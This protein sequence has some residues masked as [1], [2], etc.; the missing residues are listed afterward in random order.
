M[1]RGGVLT[2][3]P[4]LAFSTGWEKGRSTRQS[5]AVT[6]WIVAASRRCGRAPAPPRAGPSRPGRRR[7]GGT[8]AKGTDRSAPAPAAPRGGWW[9]ASQPGVRVVSEE[10]L[11]FQRRPTERPAIQHVDGHVTI[12][13]TAVGALHGIRRRQPGRGS[14]RLT[15]LGARWCPNRCL[16]VTG[17]SEDGQD[18]DRDRQ[19][20]GRRDRAPSRP[21]TS[22]ASEAQKAAG[23]MASATI[24]RS[25]AH[26][27]RRRRPTVP[28]ERRARQRLVL[29][30]GHGGLLVGRGANLRIGFALVNGR[31]V[32]AF[33]FGPK[34]GP[35]SRH[36][37]IRRGVGPARV[38]PAHR[39]GRCRR[40]SWPRAMRLP[41]RR[42]P[43][44]GDVD[45]LLW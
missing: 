41:G 32:T 7:R 5:S 23:T 33:R 37:G 21:Q 10:Q 34:S 4:Q 27:R 16:H 43:G 39:C 35:R 1:Q 30:N 18:E 2:M 3:A 17:G 26:A 11:A 13:L 14:R 25:I 12:L 6:R 36:H 9:T 42:L 31:P 15:P 20:D 28:D 24:T 40:S 44:L 45:A 8:R 29:K 19:D 38:W 22:Q